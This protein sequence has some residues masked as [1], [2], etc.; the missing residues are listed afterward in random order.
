MSEVLGPSPQARALASA[1][2]IGLRPIVGHLYGR[3]VGVK[4]LRAAVDAGSRLLR[5]LPE[6]H[7]QRLHESSES[8][9]P[10]I[11]E[12]VRPPDPQPGA[13]L[14]LHGGGYTF[15]SPETHRV[16][17]SRL[18]VDTGMPVLVPRYR[19]A[20]E[21]P[22]P[23]AFED[24][25]DAYRWL[26]GRSVPASK[27]VIAGDSAGGHLTAALVG[28]ICRAGLP[29]PAGAVLFSPWVDLTCEMSLV[30]DKQHRDP[31]IDPALAV[32]F[33]KL[34]VGA[35]DWADP[36]LALLSC[37]SAELPPFLIQ[38]GGIE[39]LRS[40]SEDLAEALRA[41]GASCE[42]QIWPGQMHVFQMFNRL[43]PEARAAMREA[44]QFARACVGA[45]AVEAAA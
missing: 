30:G 16:I 11:G 24:A 41:A 43:F 19:L 33:G 5:P 26:L 12:W 44:A 20:P 38:A 18:A 39:V 9:R 13:I 6:V 17:T 2:R 45:D 25:L 29:S 10:I 14:Y 31:Y 22:F 21:H 15:C 1:L 7:I 27:I 32:R 35:G 23:A 28:E 36:R 4:V 37:A 42:L 8:G 40:D 34:Y 3:V